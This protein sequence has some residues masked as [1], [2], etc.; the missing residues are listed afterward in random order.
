MQN[1]SWLLHPFFSNVLGA[2]SGLS[3][4]THT[5][6]S[7]RRP[8]AGIMHD[9]PRSFHLHHICS[10]C[11]KQG[12]KSTFSTRRHYAFGLVTISTSDESPQSDLHRFLGRGTRRAAFSKCKGLRGRVYCLFLPSDASPGGWLLISSASILCETAQESVIPSCCFASYE[13]YFRVFGILSTIFRLFIVCD[14]PPQ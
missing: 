9:I 6:S 12:P 5:P 13:L 11:L 10:C 7:S 4:L 3:A 1:A 14:A 8:G 2:L